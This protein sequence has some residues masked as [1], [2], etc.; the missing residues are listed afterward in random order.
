E[1]PRSLPDDM[2]PKLVLKTQNR[3]RIWRIVPDDQR[4]RRIPRLS[5]SSSNDLVSLL[6]DENVWWR[7]TAQRLLVERQDK[8]VVPALNDL[9]RRVKFAPGR[10][11]ALWTLHGLH[12]LDDDRIVAALK[13]KSA[14]VREQALR[15][16][17]DRLDKSEFVRKAAF[18]LI[19]DPSDRVRFQLAL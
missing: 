2:K 16:A 12:A 11:H 5:Q 1:T 4:A 19:E 7:L 9:A 10:A 6:A 3:G 15:L 14:L 13:D 8:T 18:A 17:E